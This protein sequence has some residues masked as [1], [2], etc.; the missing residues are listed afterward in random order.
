MM[1]VKRALKEP[2]VTDQLGAAGHVVKSVDYGKFIET[3]RTIE[4]RWTPS[5]LPP[6]GD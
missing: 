4:S 5:K 3:I 2:N 6:D 1:T